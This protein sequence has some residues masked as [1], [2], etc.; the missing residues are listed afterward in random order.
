M[1]VHRAGGHR[2][3]VAASHVRSRGREDVSDLTGGY[4]AYQLV[5]V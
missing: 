4:N 1:V 2:S 3:G 5:S